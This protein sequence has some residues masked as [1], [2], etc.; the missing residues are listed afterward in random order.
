MFGMNCTRKIAIAALVLLYGVAAAASPAIS[1]P[2]PSNEDLWKVINAA[3]K[4]GGNK[5]YNAA[6][7]L[8]SKVIKNRPNVILFLNRAKIYSRMGQYA[9]A[10]GDLDQAIEIFPNVKPAY[11]LRANARAHLGQPKLALQD[12]VDL[13]STSGD[14]ILAHRDATATY[15]RGSFE[16]KD[17]N[18]A[19]SA[20]PQNANVWF[21]KGMAEFL[22]GQYTQAINDLSTAIRRNPNFSAA[23]ILRADC[24]LSQKLNDRALVDIHASIRVDPKSITSYDAL[25]NFYFQI[26]KQE[27]AL[28]ELNRYAKSYPPPVV[29]FAR[30]NLYNK[31]DNLDKALADYSSVIQS[32]PKFSE[33][34]FARAGVY[35]SL[36]QTDK[37]LNDLTVA[38]KLEPTCG[39]FFQERAKILIDSK[40]YELAIEDL[41]KAIKCKYNTWKIYRARSSCYDRLGKHSMALQ[42]LEKSGSVGI[43]SR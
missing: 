3:E 22:A 15:L 9:K 43:F 41:T 38:L 18:Q 40:K 21:G 11:E 14:G 26:G 27:A 6:L 5:Q 37:A 12:C 34:L 42:D 23:H 32:D 19:V 7:A 39:K 30:G 36:G 35:N 10:A 29:I 1:D 17:W 16:L 24:F 25:L 20:A 8:Y 2:I 28:A 13:L 4:L 33:A 31:I